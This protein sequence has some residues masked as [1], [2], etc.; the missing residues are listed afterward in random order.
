M[1]LL[2]AEDDPEPQAPEPPEEGACCGSGCDPCVLDLYNE[3]RR[4]HLAELHAWRQRQARRG[5]PVPDTVPG[6]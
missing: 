4:R 6:S 5:A 2:P 1:S 3:Q